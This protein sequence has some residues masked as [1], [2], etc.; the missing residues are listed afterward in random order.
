MRKILLPL[1]LTVVFPVV[2]LRAAS[3][4]EKVAQVVSGELKEACVSW[5]GF[6]AEDSTKFLQTAIDSKVPVLVVDRQGGPWITGPLTLQSD[7]EIRF[8]EDVELSAK[9]G[10]FHGKAD[11][12]LAA[13]NRKNIKLIGLG[14]GATFRMR[15]ADY[16]GEEYSKSE[17]RH[18]LSIRSSENIW[19]ENLSMVSSG[20]D[21]IYVGVATRGV[22][23]RN[24]TIRKVVCDDNNRQ[25]I[26]VISADKLLIEDTVLKNTWGTPPAAGIDFEPNLPDEQ[27]T[28]C[29][30]RNCIVENNAGDGIVFY[31]PN[32]LESEK[33]VSIRLENCR[34]KSG[35]RYGFNFI[36]RDTPEL[37][38]KGTCEL[39]GC[40][41]ENCGAG[42]ISIR[43][44]S[45]DGV[46]VTMKNTEVVNCG[47]DE[48]TGASVQLVMSEFDDF[49]GIDFGELKIVDPIDRLPVRLTDIA[50]WPE[51][52]MGNLTVDRN[53]KTD[54]IRIDDEW[55]AEHYPNRLKP[56][57]SIKLDPM[58]FVPTKKTDPEV[59]RPIPTFWQRKKGVFWIYAEKGTPIRL[60]LGV[61]KIGRIDV[62]SSTGTL[63][64]PGGEMKKFTIS[65]DRSASFDYRLETVPETGVHQ[66]QVDVGS[67]A[68]RMIRC[69]QPVVIPALPRLALIA[70]TGKLFFN[71]PQGT[72]EFGVRIRGEGTEAVK[73]SVV[74]PD[75]KTV[76]TEDGITSAVQFDRSAEDGAIHGVWQ[77]ELARPTGM[78]FEDFNI[79][80]LGVSPLLGFSP[81]EL[82]FSTLR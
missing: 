36:T 23:C 75:G 41:F 5:W 73:A 50:S 31:L 38:L 30:M 70:S 67:H 55:F 22:P 56:I 35:K 57:T 65:P 77:I 11:A 54:K 62:G 14:R 82:P 9:K 69:N 66:L 74:A 24:V 63:T 44:K 37:K 68:V 71:V 28:D 18:A 46:A 53:E 17:W 15:K 49:G 52:V 76:W 60:A 26:S 16:H 72:K 2:G 4:P 43:Q 33:P 58:A 34:V 3:D 32:L 12:L 78:V 39:V 81:D 45:V 13:P 61:R 6:D 48:K 8:E 1:L 20:G 79:T 40:R 7:Q 47:T 51:R 10:L 59:D 80:I 21:G 42:G 19:V 64:F 27:L 25:G 29:V